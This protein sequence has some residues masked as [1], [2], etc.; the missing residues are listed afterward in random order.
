[1]TAANKKAVV[2]FTEG[3]I[4]GK[5][6]K[7]AMP[8]MATALLQ[9]LY[10]AA[11]MIVVA[12]FAPNGSFAMGAVGACGSLFSLFVNFFLGHGFHIGFYV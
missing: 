5:M 1:M 6:I 11:D 8:L 7:F 10:N 4:T 9:S 12:N 2:D 3:R